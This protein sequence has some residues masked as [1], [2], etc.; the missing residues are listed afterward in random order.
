VKNNIASDSNNS[1]VF[2]DDQ[3][4]SLGTKKEFHSNQQ[5]I[6]IANHQNIPIGILG[7]CGQGHHSGEWKKPR[8]YTK[9][10]RIQTLADNKYRANGEGITFE[11]PMSA[12]LALHK[13]QAQTTLK[14]CLQ[15]GILFTLRR[16]NPQI[17]YPV[18]QKSEII[19]KNIRK[20]VTGVIYSKPT[21]FPNNQS[22]KNADIILQGKT[23]DS[24]AIQTL[25]GYILPLLPKAPSHIHK[26]QLKLKIDPQY[27]DGIVLPAANQQN[28]GRK[29]E[30]II[31]NTGVLYH[32]YP[33]GTIVVSAECSNK[34][35]KLE[36][37]YDRSQLLAFFGQ[38]RDRLVLLLRDNHE[39]IVP[40]IMQWYLTQCDINKDIRVGDWLQFFGLR[41]QV[42]H[43]DHLFRIYI[44]SM[45][46]NTVCRVEESCNSVN[47]PVI[48]AIN[49][50]FNPYEKLG[51]QFAG[52]DKK[53]NEIRNLLQE[54]VNRTNGNETRGE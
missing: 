19:K 31:G 17:Y 39:R 18:C 36:D 15:R 42:R 54:L 30:E 38:V 10:D 35:Y 14:H 43:L 27:Y 52:H 3:Q 23:Q 24:L 25:E 22:Y 2:E 34:P 45:G 50:I 33:N 9:A 28:K 1:V 32:L 21:H 49:D 12:G 26:I 41:I 13:E 6:P 51:R 44:K 29:H 46:P 47:K 20:E 5:N 11:D 8:R 53:L 7:Q 40:E 4:A 37:E 48:E 16:R